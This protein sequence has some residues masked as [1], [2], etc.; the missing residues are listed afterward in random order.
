[1]TGQS[2]GIA[3]GQSSTGRLAVRKQLPQN[4]FTLSWTHYVCLLGIKNSEERSFYEIESLQSGWNVRELKR[5]K[6]SCLYERLALSRDK[7]GVKRLSQKGQIVTRPEDVMKEPLVLEFLGLDEKAGYSETDL[8]SA[9]I[10]HLEKR[11]GI[12]TLPAIK[13]TAQTETSGLDPRSGGSDQEMSP[14]FEELL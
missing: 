4:P 6:A 11:K 14:D 7:E 9:L 1:M 2:S 8:E 10:S 3:I 5:Q 13:R 12:P